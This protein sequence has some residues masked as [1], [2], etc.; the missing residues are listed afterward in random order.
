MCGASNIQYEFISSAC[1]VRRNNRDFIE[2]FQRYGVDF[3]PAIALSFSIRAETIQ[4]SASEEKY[5]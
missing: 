4:R 2:T 5:V 1:I 3:Q